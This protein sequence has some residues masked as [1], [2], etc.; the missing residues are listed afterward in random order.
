MPEHTGSILEEKPPSCPE[1][2]GWN[3]KIQNIPIWGIT[4]EWYCPD[5]E[6]LWRTTDSGESAEVYYLPSSKVFHGSEDC[7]GSK[8]KQIKSTLPEVEESKR[9]C[10]SCVGRVLRKLYES[11]LNKH[12]STSNVD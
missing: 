8:V 5:C 6:N 1:C 10:E 4:W 9:P 12:D 11:R 7:S 2:G 3:H